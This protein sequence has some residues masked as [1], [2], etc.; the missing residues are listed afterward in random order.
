MAA[1]IVLFGSVK[2]VM[3]QVTKKPDVQKIAAPKDSSSGAVTSLR[4]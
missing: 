4:K 3:T 2:E 1:I